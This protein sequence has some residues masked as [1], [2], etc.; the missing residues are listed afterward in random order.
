MVTFAVVLLGFVAMVNAGERLEAGTK[1]V[2]QISSGDAATQDLVLHNVANLQKELGIGNVEIEI[3]AFGPGVEMLTI[4]SPLR[5]RVENMVSQ[6]IRFSA[7]ENTMAAIERN[8]GEKLELAKGVDI[9][10][11]GIARIVELQKQ[12]YTYVRP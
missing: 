4:N 8:S 1:T 9:V 3:V 6:N 2:I 12:G 5:D 7:C 10:S 11:S